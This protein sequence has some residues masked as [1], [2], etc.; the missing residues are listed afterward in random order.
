ML[1]GCLWFAAV[2][3]ANMQSWWY[4]FWENM[5]L[6]ITS[7][8]PLQ[9]QGLKQKGSVCVREKGDSYSCGCMQQS[10][11]CEHMWKTLQNKSKKLFLIIFN[12]L[13]LYCM[14]LPQWIMIMFKLWT[15][16][17]AYALIIC[18]M[19]VSEAAPTRWELCYYSYEN[20]I[21]T[22]K[23][24]DYHLHAE[25][26]IATLLY[27]SKKTKQTIT[28]HSFWFTLCAIVFTLDNTY[29]LWASTLAEPERSMHCTVIECV[30][31]EPVRN[32]CQMES[33]YQMM[34]PKGC[35]ELWRS[36]CR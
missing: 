10:K 18:Q 5:Q 20:K 26:N 14:C 17:L 36:S 28:S 24:Y 8:F 19:Y 23:K 1:L 6:L 30:F 11:C 21:L 27:S 12:C 4:S 2:N 34:T 29:N 16:F 31:S 13:V 33:H 15:L 25:W 22:F 32:P 7:C 3:F 35:S 9:L